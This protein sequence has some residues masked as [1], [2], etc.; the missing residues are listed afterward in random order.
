[1]EFATPGTA[2][3]IGPAFATLAEHHVEALLVCA[4]PLFD[5]Q[6]GLIVALAAKFKLLA[7]YQ[8]REY[9]VAGGLMSYGISLVEGYRQVGTYAGQ[10]LQGAKPAELPVYETVKF[11]FIVNLKTAKTL[12]VKLSDNLLSIADEVIE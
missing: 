5:T 9:A 8:F 10:V 1:M 3:E 7:I 6:R 12:G 11:E 4:D 2:Q